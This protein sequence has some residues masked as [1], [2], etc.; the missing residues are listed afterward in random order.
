VLSCPAKAASSN[1]GTGIYFGR[2]DYWIT[3]LRG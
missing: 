1:P 3:R 2:T